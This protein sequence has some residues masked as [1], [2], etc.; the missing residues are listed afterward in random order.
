MFRLFVICGHRQGV[1]MPPIVGLAIE[2][3]Y[4]ALVTSQ[5]EL[6]LRCPSAQLIFSVAMLLGRWSVLRFAFVCVV[7]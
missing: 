2:S 3:K 5:R 6:D 1:A 7:E 4:R